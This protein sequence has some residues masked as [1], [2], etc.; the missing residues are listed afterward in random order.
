MAYTN[1]HMCIINTYKRK[2]CEAIEVFIS[3]HTQKIIVDIYRF[4]P[5]L[6][7]PYFP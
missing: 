7:L 1:K 2:N 3:L 5:L 4:L 6:H